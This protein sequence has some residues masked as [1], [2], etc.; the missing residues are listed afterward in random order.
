MI[1]QKLEIIKRL[2][3]GKSQQE[4]IASYG[5]RSSTMCDV[6]KQKDQL[7]YFMTSSESVKGLFK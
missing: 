6:E 2:E 4:V 1:P 7:Q 5:I 3:S